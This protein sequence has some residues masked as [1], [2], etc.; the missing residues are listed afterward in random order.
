MSVSL[1]VRLSTCQFVRVCVCRFVC[2]SVGLSFCL[3]VYLSVCVSVYLSAC[4]SV[5]L[6]VCLFLY[7]PFL[8]SV[9]FNV[10]LSL[11]LFACFSVCLSVY[12]TLSSP[13][14]SSSNFY[15][16][17]LA[18]LFSHIFSIDVKLAEK[19]S[20]NLYYHNK[21]FCGRCLLASKTKRGNR[22]ILMIRK[23]LFLSLKKLKSFSHAMSFFLRALKYTIFSSLN[24][25][26]H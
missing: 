18:Y 20:K 3:S 24:V 7:L 26:M 10:S 22:N 16:Y 23:L 12:F 21:C 14:S 2:L 1:F 17:F 13:P 6:F 11:C 15:P 4:Q 8:F 9:C 5:N 19:P 25:Y